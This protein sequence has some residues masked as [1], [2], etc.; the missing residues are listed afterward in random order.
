MHRRL[1]CSRFVHNCKQNRL[2]PCQVVRHSAGR[3][4]DAATP[5]ECPRC[6]ALGRVVIERVIGWE[7][8]EHGKKVAMTDVKVWFCGR[9]NRLLHKA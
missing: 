2:D 9:C 8:D 1:E 7:R 3:A 5:P 6:R 4:R